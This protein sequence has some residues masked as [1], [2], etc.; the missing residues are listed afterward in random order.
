MRTPTLAE[1][2]S[3]PE[4]KT[5]WPWTEETP[6][7]PILPELGGS[8][9]KVSI[10]T[11]SFNQGE[12]IEE[13]IRSVLLQ[14]YPDLE[15]II[16]DGGSTD[17]SVDIIEKYKE[18]LAFWVSERDGGVTNGC[19]KGFSKAT[20]ELLGMM[21]ADD[22]YKPGGIINLV[23]L[24]FEKP[25]SVGFVGGCPEVDLFGSLVNPGIPFIKDQSAVGDWGVRGWF[26]S[27]ACLFRADLF[28][29]VGRFD[30]R[31]RS[32]NDVDLWVKLSKIG[33]FSLTDQIVATARWNPQSIS[34]RDKPG[35]LCAWIAS[36]YFNGYIDVAKQIL[37]RY[38][39]EQVRG[40]LENSNARPHFA[41]R[42]IGRLKRRI[43]RLF[44]VKREC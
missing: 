1:L 16:I 17:N 5:G 27:V 11:P 12:F 30:E 20:G 44:S 28:Q 13:T 38:G 37:I 3:P 33:P 10:V 24:W 25:E 40:G 22:Y 21:C 35:E 29:Q 8:W 23:G 6:Q 15:Y 18:W 34:H 41:R 9:P 4:G 26:V 7:A 36:N 42:F 43:L 19:N 14:G 2:P 32:G 31:F 39:R